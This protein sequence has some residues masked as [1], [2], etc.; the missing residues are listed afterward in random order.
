[1]ADNIAF[2]QVLLRVD[3]NAHFHSRDV[4]VH[5]LLLISGLIKRPENHQPAGRTY[6]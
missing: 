2:E 4:E 3:P 6:G 1:M 5:V